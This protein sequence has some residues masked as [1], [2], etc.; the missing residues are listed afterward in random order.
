MEDGPPSFPRGF[1]CPVVLGVSL[2][3][4]RVSRTGLS[5]SVEELSSSFRYPSGVPRRDP[6]TP[7]TLSNPRFGLLRFRSPLLA[8]SLLI[9]SPPGTEMFQF[10]G[11]ASPC[12]DDG[13][14]RPPGFPIRKSTDQRL[15]SGSPWLIAA[16]RVLHRLS[17]PRHPPSALVELDLEILNPIKATAQTR[18]ITHPIRLSKTIRPAKTKRKGPNPIAASPLALTPCQNSQWR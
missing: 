9:S 4:F 11:F 18:N 15:F 5:P 3:S 2:G 16:H 17:A 12:G 8:E 13:P 6:T 7:G 1:T 10:P 14:L